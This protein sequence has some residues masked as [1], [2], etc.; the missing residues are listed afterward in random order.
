V[1]GPRIE[2]IE[3]ARAALKV[4]EA[5]LAFAERELADTKLY[6]HSDGIIEDRILQP[7]DMASPG[8]PAF[9]MVLTDPL[10][11]HGYGNRDTRRIAHDLQRLFTDQPVQPHGSLFIHAAL[12]L[13]Y[14][15]RT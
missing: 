1:K 15:R 9:T 6:A 8:V 4:D 3:N 10:W 11:V 7:G 2:D 5:A 13:D 14:F 12:S